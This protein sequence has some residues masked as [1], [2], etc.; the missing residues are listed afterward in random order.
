MDY[1][2]EPYSRFN[3]KRKNLTFIGL[4]V[5]KKSK[6]N[7]KKPKPALNT[8]YTL[9]RLFGGSGLRKT[10]VGLTPFMWFCLRH[11]LGRGHLLRKVL[12]PAQT[13]SYLERYM[14]DAKYWKNIFTE[15][16]LHNTN[17]INGV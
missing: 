13:V 8:R 3:L 17:A 10:T 1:S 6:E 9:R 2:S 4:C 16:F 7:I 15:I 14:T 5:F 12:L 11:S